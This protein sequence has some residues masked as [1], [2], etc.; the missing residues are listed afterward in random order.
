MFEDFNLITEE[1]EVEYK[2]IIDLSY[3]NKGE[4]V[5]L[6]VD[7]FYTGDVKVYLDSEMDGREY[8]CLNHEIIYLD[9]IKDTSHE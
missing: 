1:D 4:V 9:S 6:F 7:D 3:K 2:N 5:E 8:I